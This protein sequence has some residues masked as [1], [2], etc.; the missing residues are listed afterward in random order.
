MRNQLGWIQFNYLYM[1]LFIG[2]IVS[3]AMANYQSQEGRWMQQEKLGMMPDGGSINLPMQYS[4]SLSL[5]LAFQD[6]PILMLDSAGLWGYSVHYT[7]T[8]V[9]AQRVGYPSEAA[10]AVAAADE[11]ID[12]GSTSPIWGDQSYHFNR[13]LSGGED[14]RLMHFREHYRWAE[15]FCHRGIDEPENAV[16]DLGSSLHPLQ[17]W[18]A[19]GD[20]GMKDKGRA[21]W[22]NYHSPQ[23]DYGPS[24]DYP[25]DPTLDVVNSPDGRAA[26]IYIV[27]SLEIRHPG[28]GFA[29]YYSD[30][31]YYE[32]GFKR[33]NLTRVMTIEELKNWLW[34]VKTEGG[35]KCKKYFGVE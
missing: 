28:G 4:E 23:G 18:V 14:S 30:F 3:P 13:N 21:G 7:K 33:Y 20:Y 8:R 16:K 27:N 32:K 12:H 31:A 26:K 22:H 10:S 34:Y 5:Y 19:H 29:E 1:F 9:W 11:A 35:C 17:D 25:D 6:M 2:I 15:I 24:Q